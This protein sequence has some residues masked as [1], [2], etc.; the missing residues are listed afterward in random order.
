MKK[1]RKAGYRPAKVRGLNVENWFKDCIIVA[2]YKMNWARYEQ[3]LY[4]CWDDSLRLDWMV[5]RSQIWDW[6]RLGG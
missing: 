3:A 2:G 6:D 1:F 5:D 4:F